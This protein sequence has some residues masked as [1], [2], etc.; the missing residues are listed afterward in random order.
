MDIVIWLSL[1]FFVAS[2]IYVWLMFHEVSH[3]AVD[4]AFDAVAYNSEDMEGQEDQ[5][6]SSPP[7][8]I[9]SIGTTSIF[10]GTRIIG[11]SLAFFLVMLLFKAVFTGMNV[12]SLGN[13]NVNML[14]NIG[15][16]PVF[17]FTKISLNKQY[18]VKAAV[19]S[20]L[21]I[22]FYSKIGIQEEDLYIKSACHMHVDIMMFIILCIFIAISIDILRKHL[23]D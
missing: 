16:D 1:V 10:I 19:L 13:L 15:S 8:N 17:I 14:K 6:D 4:D 18:I 7:F 12:S 11:A 2:L 22:L 5:K 9:N 3:T 23:K 21:G 20:I